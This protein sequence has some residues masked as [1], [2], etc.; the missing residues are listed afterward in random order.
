M[1]VIDC[2]LPEVLLEAAELAAGVSATVRQ[3]GVFGESAAA[4]IVVPATGGMA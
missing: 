2:A 3:T 4:T 1:R